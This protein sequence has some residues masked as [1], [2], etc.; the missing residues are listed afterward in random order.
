MAFLI[1]LLWLGIA[2]AAVIGNY[3]NYDNDDVYWQKIEEKLEDMERRIV[4]LELESKFP[5]ISILSIY[6]LSIYL[7][8][9]RRS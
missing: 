8:L 7:L 1:I 9:L 6:L 5:S 4:A 2:N 3:D